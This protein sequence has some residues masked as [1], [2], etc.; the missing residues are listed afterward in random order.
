M[1]ADKEVEEQ[2]NP[3]DT[4]ILF[5]LKHAYNEKDLKA[6][7][8]FADKNI[9]HVVLS[10]THPYFVNNQQLGEEILAK[11][12]SK[13]R[14][15]YVNDLKWSE[16]KDLDLQ[17]PNDGAKQKLE[18]LDVKSFLVQLEEKLKFCSS[19]QLLK[20]LQSDHF[21]LI[22]RLYG[23]RIGHL[24]E[25]LEVFLH[26][27]NDHQNSDISGRDIDGEKRKATSENSICYDELLEESIEEHSSRYYGRILHEFDLEDRI[28]GMGKSEEMLLYE[29]PPFNDVCLWEFMLVACKILPIVSVQGVDNFLA[30]GTENKGLPKLK[31]MWVMHEFF[32]CDSELLWGYLEKGF[33]EWVN[34]RQLDDDVDNAGE[35]DKMTSVHSKEDQALNAGENGNGYLTVSP[36]I[37]YVVT[38]KIYHADKDPVLATSRHQHMFDRMVI[39]NMTIDLRDM[40]SERG[41]LERSERNHLES[42]FSAKRRYYNGELTKEEFERVEIELRQRD[43]HLE[44][45]LDELNYRENVALQTKGEAEK[46]LWRTKL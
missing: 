38:E 41:G 22:F 2:Y 23:G 25:W 31:P 44:N 9:C 3:K 43:H 35:E 42:W 40:K 7:I 4:A 10:S 33:I 45:M 8:D 26:A 13:L 36:L 16:D 1:L 15:F 20:T 37:K 30:E 21:D 18:R 32:L 27:C 17:D 29:S 19:C 12:V 34:A 28:F 5:P 14:T 39:R 46:N 6:I 24:K 11:L